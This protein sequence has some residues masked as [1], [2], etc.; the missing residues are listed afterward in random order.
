MKSFHNH[1]VMLIENDCLDEKS[2][3]Y[4]IR[5]IIC[6]RLL[7][8]IPLHVTPNMLKLVYKSISEEI[9]LG[10]EFLRCLIKFFVFLELNLNI[11]SQVDRSTANS[12]SGFWWIMKLIY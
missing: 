8:K 3:I 7:K 2:A 9:N 1:D 6:I 12:A 10:S 5:T 4:G 11:Q